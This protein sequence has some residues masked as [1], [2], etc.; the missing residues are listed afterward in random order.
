MR[1]RFSTTVPEWLRD[2]LHE[3]ITE[4]T[5]KVNMSA[6]EIH[7]K[8][9]REG[10]GFAGYAYDGPPG[11]NNVATTSKYLVTLH[12]PW[13]KWP[14]YP[15]NWQYPGLRT[16]PVLKLVSWQ[17]DFFHKVAHEAYH[18]KQ[19]RT[20]MSQSEV[21]A[22]RWALKRLIEEGRHQEVEDVA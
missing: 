11:I 8:T 18:I 16:A 21:K 17:D 13:Q 6:V 10:Y 2:E 20:G 22:E 1:V 5:Y 15:R 14:K 9:A 7:V 4:A 19:F 12:V 3:I